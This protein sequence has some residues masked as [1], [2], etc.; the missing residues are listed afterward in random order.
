MTMLPSIQAIEQDAA[1]AAKEKWIEE[2]R[3]VIQKLLDDNETPDGIVLTILKLL[4]RLLIIPVKLAIKLTG[5]L[6]IKLP[7]KILWFLQLILPP[8]NIF[9]FNSW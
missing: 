5:F 9:P 6:L 2:N 1:V 7:L 4:I 3:E 8:Y